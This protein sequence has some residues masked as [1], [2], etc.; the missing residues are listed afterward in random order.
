MKKIYAA[1]TIFLFTFFYSQVPQG[2]SY[3]T[4]AFNA[5]G[6]PI[7]D[8]Y[9]SLRV[10]ILDNSATGTVLY[11]ETHN[12]T[13][14]NKGLVNLN[15][16]QGTVVTGTFS[17]INWGTNPKFV[18]VEMDPAGGS[19]YTSVGVNQLMSVPYAMVAGTTTSG[20]SAWNLNSNNRLSY[21]N[22]DIELD[23]SGSSIYLTSPNGTKYKL[24][25]DDSGQISL[26]FINGNVAQYP[27]QLYMYGSYNS[28]NPSSS[29]L[30]TVDTSWYRYGYKYLSSGTKIKFIS[31]QSNN[32]QLFGIDGSGSVVSNGA[33]YNVI[34]NG[35]YLIKLDRSYTANP[36]TTN[37]NL[38][39][40]PFAPQLVLSNFA[41]I[42]PTYNPSTNKFSFIVNN[43]SSTNKP[44]F[45]F[46]FYNVNGTS[47][48]DGSY[49]D[50]LGDGSIEIYGTPITFQNLTTTPKNFRVDLTINFNGQAIYT[51]TQI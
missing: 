2:F 51:I 31:S 37:Y 19:N 36:E 8:G 7:A 43:I 50:Y 18:K 12:K 34:S 47:S 24:A 25:V 4:I 5:A 22:G 13:T 28:W 44:T 15:I 32:G 27:I 6:A 45:K 46:N 42:N 40:I 33:E 38:L 1:L 20:N 41:T 35:F 16:G 23:K 30:L 11:T 29:E 3:Q 10:S 26:P 9:V 39:M 49:G 48:S 14:N 21:N 17:G